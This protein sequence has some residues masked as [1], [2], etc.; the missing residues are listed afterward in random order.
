MI[1]INKEIPMLTIVILGG[2]VAVVAF[3]T[4]LQIRNL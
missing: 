3:V 2:F 1:Y 4:Y